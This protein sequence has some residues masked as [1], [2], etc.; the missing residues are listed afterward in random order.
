MK[1]LKIVLL[2]I[3]FSS[4]YAFADEKPHVNEKMFCV[5]DN[6]DNSLDIP[7]NNSLEL[8]SLDKTSPSPSYSKSKRF[9]TP[10]WCASDLQVRGEPDPGGGLRP[11]LPPHFLNVGGYL[12][13]DYY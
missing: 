9:I 5:K 2:I 10:G 13:L 1:T 3:S 6:L 12:I 4:I 11:P 7:S 8:S